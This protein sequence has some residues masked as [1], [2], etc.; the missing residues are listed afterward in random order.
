MVTHTDEYYGVCRISRE[1][2][3]QVASG[4]LFPAALAERDPGEYWDECVSQLIDP[5]FVLAKV[6]HESSGLKAGIALI[7]KSWGN[8]RKPNF[9]AEPIGYTEPGQA[10]SGIFPIWAS[11][12]DGLRST[13]ARLATEDY[14]YRYERRNIGQ[15]Y[16]DPIADNP[17]YRPAMPPVPRARN[18][19]GQVMR[20]EWAPAGDLNNPAGYLASVLSYINL[21][22]DQTVSLLGGNPVPTVEERFLADMRSLGL[23][24]TNLHG[25]LPVNRNTRYQYGKLPGG[26]S[27]AEYIAVHWTGDAFSD[28]TIRIITGTNYNTGGKISPDMTVD[29]EIDMV[30]WYAAYHVSKDGGT[31][32]GIAYH[33]LV[34]PSGRI[35][36][37]W[38]LDTWTYH[39]FNANDDS[40]A[41]CC[42]NSRGAEPTHQQLVGLNAVLLWLTT[43]CPEIPA[44][45]TKVYGH[46]ELTM[47]DSRNGGTQC[48]GTLLPTVREF[49][50]TGRATVDISTPNPVPIDSTT[51][52]NIDQ[53]NKRALL[54]DAAN[55]LPF[56]FRGHLEREGWF[57]LSNPP[58]G[59]EVGQSTERW[60]AYKSFRIHTINGRV[61]SFAL[62]GPGSFEW[63]KNL[64]L[65]GEW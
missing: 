35:Y 22:S 43:Q 33:V 39:A 23:I 40:I 34:F 28:E 59:I 56:T 62:E 15:V 49:R 16:N 1:K 13:C 31:W 42:P 51:P 45:H 61:E 63:F 37:N 55:A 60:A 65:L 10:R 8:T 3:R 57:N 36:L 18:A 52:Y 27:G 21:I 2:F 29:D 9:G 20:I 64:G 4:L 11:Y 17:N 6:K 50:A 12:L 44:D 14:Y 48:P 46:R 30:K 26:Y 54:L 41:V 47:L 32:G 19:A 7:T 25:Q 24:A 5:A 53:A 38:P 58:A